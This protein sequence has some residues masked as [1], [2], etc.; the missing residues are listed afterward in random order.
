MI[1][2]TQTLQQPQPQPPAGACVRQVLSEDRLF[3]APPFMQVPRKKACSNFF[4]C[5]DKDP[6]HINAYVHACKFGQSCR[7]LGDPRHT[8]T[9]Y[10][11]NH[12]VCKFGNSCTSM[13]DPY[14]RCK[15]HHPGFCDFLIPCN[16]VN[17]CSQINNPKHI[18]KF[19]HLGYEVY[20]EIPPE[21]K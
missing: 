17:S 9:Y 11:Y 19:S 20:P 1:Y 6:A 16:Y 10:H 8:S 3:Q 13:N 2:G 12:T 15:Y 5:K 18:E 4:D 21:L 14:H 7:Y